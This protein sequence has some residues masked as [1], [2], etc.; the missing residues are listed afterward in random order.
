MRYQNGFQNPFDYDSAGW[1]P[2]CYAC[3]KGD[4]SL[5]AALLKQRVDPNEKIKKAQGDT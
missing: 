4:V 2:M 5:V 1:S 3:M